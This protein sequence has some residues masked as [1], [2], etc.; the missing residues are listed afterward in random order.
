[1]REV[2]ADPQL[3][4]REALA[5]VQDAGG[6]F[7]VVNPPFRMSAATAQVGGFAAALGE[8]TRDV[9]RQAGYSDAQIEAFA[10][11]GAIGVA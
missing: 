1:V 10:A 6:S 8:H 4:H 7:R 5:E 2:L 9:L 11:G 3:A